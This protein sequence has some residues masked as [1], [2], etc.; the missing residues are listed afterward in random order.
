MLLGRASIA[1]VVAIACIG[2]ALL[3]AWPKAAAA[4]TVAEDAV[5]TSLTIDLSQDRIKWGEDV[6]VTVSVTNNTGTTVAGGLYVSFDDEA[7]FLDVTGGELLRRGA[8]AFNL[9]TS[10]S[11]P[12]SRPMVESWE[13]AWKPGVQR[14]VVLKV[15]PL[16]RDR[17]RVLARAT[18]VPQGQ[19]KKILI[20]PTTFESR[21]LDQTKF[22]A[23]VSYIY[24]SRQGSLRKTFRRFEQRLRQL[25]DA[26]R[27][28]FANALAAVLEDRASLESLIAD[29]GATGI[30]QSLALVAPQ[31][32][33]KLRRD[34]PVALEKLRCLLVDVGCS[35]AAVYFGM[36]L[37]VYQGKSAAEA[38]RLD[39]KTRISSEKGGN[40][41]V[42]LLESAG[43][44]YRQ[45]KSQSAI[46]VD[47]NGISI[48]VDT[49]GPVVVELLNRIIPLLGQAA[50]KPH[51]ESNNLSFV[52]LRARLGDGTPK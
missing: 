24:I 52:R 42:A 18:F 47:V 5:N 10:D 26:E 12:I 33:D 29:E 37:A 44:S 14:Q 43:L 27:T 32:A 39:A 19:S 38:A 16:A 7:L 21:S 17:L 50:D 11:K 51:A 6:V 49:A 3:A 1:R 36:P 34:A 28:V 30:K 40:E 9:A 35:D 22:P 48:S 20:A 15:M 2:A 31:I 8:A 41:L 25:D 45:D 46:L 23:T 13:D 4:A